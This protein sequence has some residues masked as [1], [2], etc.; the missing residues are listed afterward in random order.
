MAQSTQVKNFPW[1]NSLLKNLFNTKRISVT[2]KLHNDFKEHVMHSK[3]NH[4]LRWAPSNNLETIA[5][6]EEGQ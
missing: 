5:K 1:N 6:Q 3:N 2:W 4:T